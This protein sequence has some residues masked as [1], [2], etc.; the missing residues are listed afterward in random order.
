MS[1]EAMPPANV[2]SRSAQGMRI[3]RRLVSQS[4]P[5]RYGNILSYSAH[6]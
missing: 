6:I 3:P 2:S 5:I 1:A 4:L